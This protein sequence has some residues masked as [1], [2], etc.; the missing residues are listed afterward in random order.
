MTP[1]ERIEVTKAL[2]RNKRMAE[3]ALA[4]EFRLYRL[5]LELNKWIEEPNRESPAIRDL[6]TV[7][8]MRMVKDISDRNV[9]TATAAKILSSVITALGFD[10]HVSR[11]SRETDGLQD[12]PLSFP[13][14]KLI[15][16]KTN[17]PYYNFM[18]ITEHPIVWQLR[19]FGEFMDRSMDSQPDTRVSFDPD[20]WQRQVLDSID[21]GH[22]LLVVGTR[23]P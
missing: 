3:G 13:F 11:L 2:F 20:G 8:V 16:S 17:T 19:L 10:K 22:S 21:N 4:L 14:V 23:L 7:S 1:S 5:N 6:Y 15:K 9:I 12:R 18:S